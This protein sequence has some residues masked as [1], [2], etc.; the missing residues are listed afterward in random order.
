M[1]DLTLRLIITAITDGARD[2]LRQAQN[3]LND[4]RSTGEQAATRIRSVFT[5]LWAQMNGLGSRALSAIASGF[6]LIKSVGMSAWS[7]LSVGI[8]NNIDAAADFA[9]KLGGIRGGLLGLLAFKKSDFLDLWGGFAVRAGLLGVQVNEAKNF[10]SAFAD[11]KK[12]VEGTS[13]ELD[14]LEKTIKR[15]ASKEI[16]L[17]LVD[18][19]NITEAGGQLGVATSELEDFIKLASRSS[20]A[21]QG[22]T[23]QEAGSYIGGL[24]AVYEATI[25]EISPLIDQINVL[26]N[27]TNATE[28][29]ILN[30]LLMIGSGG[31]RFGLLRG[32][33]A[34][35]VTTMLSMKKPPDEVRTSLGSLFSA[36]TTG[37]MR[38][39]DFNASL[40]K[41]GLSAEQLALDIQANPMQALL[42]FLTVLGRFS[43][44]EQSNLLYGLFGQGTDVQSIGQLSFA[45][46]TLRANIDRVKEPAS[47][48][49]SALREFEKRA[50]TLENKL[51]LARNA[52]DILNIEM[53]NPFLAPVKAATDLFHKLMDSLGR[54]AADHPVL[55]AFIRIIALVQSL[56][57]VLN[58]LITVLPLATRALLQFL[59]VL[60]GTPFGGFAKNILAATVAVTVL[61]GVVGGFNSLLLSVAIAL[62]LVGY[63]AVKAFQAAGAS[64]TVF[65]AILT[66]V[67][68]TV[69]SL[70]LAF[71]GG[72]VKFVII[73]IT[74][75][76]VAY[77]NLQD[78]L[79][80]VGGI[81]AKVSNV[82][83]AA[84]RLLSRIVGEAI[85]AVGGYISQFGG[86]LLGLVGINETTWA[87]ITNAIKQF[88]DNSPGQIKAWAN[89][90][91]GALIW[92]KDN[93]GIRLDEFV[94]I[95]RVKFKG[96]VELAKAAG[97]DIK[98]AL[99]GK[100]DTSNIDA[101][102]AA[103]TTDTDK[104]NQN[105]DQQSA[106]AG[107]KDFGVDY[108]GNALN[109]ADQVLA[110][111]GHEIADEIKREG[112]KNAI[113]LPP[114]EQRGSSVGNGNLGLGDTGTE[115][116]KIP[117]DA[118]KA[119]LDL[120]L[121]AI[122][123]R[124][125]A[126]TAAHDLE[127]KQLDST[128]NAQKLELERQVVEQT[129]T[130]QQKNEQTLAL[131]KELDDKKLTV[132][133]Q[134]IEASSGLDKA[135]IL[136][137]K[138]AEQASVPGGAYAPLLDAAQQ[139]QRLPD[140]LLRAVMQVESQGNLKAVSPA[141]A[142]GLMQLMP[143][144]AKSLGVKDVF[145]PK[146]NIEGGAKLL[147]ELLDTFNGDVNKA[148]AA[149]NSNPTKVKA[150]QGDI[151][152]LPAETQAYV[153]KVQ[154]ELQ[155]PT[156]GGT[157]EER[158]A[159][160]NKIK[161]LDNEL[162]A[163][164]QDRVARLKNLG[165]DEQANATEQSTA[166]LE[167][168][169]TTLAEQKALTEA[170]L[171]AGHDAALDAVTVQEQA[172]QQ[173][174]DLG[175]LTASEHLGRLRQFAADRLAIELK[176]LNEK[177]KLL[178]DDKLALAQNLD[179]QK[180][181]IRKFGLDV[182]GINNQ[183]ATNNKAIFE[184]MMAPFKNAL[185][186]MT[187]G[188][189]T[190]QQTISNAVRNAANSMLV[191]Y[192]STFIQERVM[193]TAQ[194]AWKLSGI[195]ATGAAE[196]ALKNGD[197][198]YAMLIAA[199]EK[200]I[201]AAQ[202]AWEAA[203]E[204]RLALRKRAIKLASALW[205]KAQWVKDK[206]F[207][208]AQWAWELL[209]F[210]EKEAAKVATKT[211]TETV[212]TTAQVTNDVVRTGSTIA[213]NETAQASTASKAKSSI[214]AQAAEAAVSAYNA[215]AS[216]PYIGP[217]LGAVAAVAAFAAMMAYGAMIPSSKKGL[218]SVPE[219]RMQMVHEQETILPAGVADNFRSV[220]NF[221]KSNG[222]QATDVSAV[223]GDL[224]AN[225]QLHGNWA[226][227]KSIA[228]LPQQSSEQAATMAQAARR[229]H[230]TATAE[231]LAAMQPVNHTTHKTINEGDTHFNVSAVDGQSVKR[232][233]ENHGDTLA[234]VVRDKARTGKSLKS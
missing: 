149:Y 26:G 134:Y 20:V 229:N 49:G 50:D 184:G 85:D 215:M 48:A 92:L 44:L 87:R 122:K 151:K 15:M 75:L 5:V 53:G 179:D 178:K 62:G 203:G 137:K 17:K 84:W 12:V 52:L 164:E 120:Q 146:Q 177:R 152:K 117:T 161:L 173:E 190:G 234:R 216:I 11:V 90:V 186:Q 129:I 158:Q 109:F 99:A 181:L 96:A 98:D 60:A 22:L 42:N 154:A 19:A 106:A 74:S 69:G 222:L 35:L 108:I 110:D 101:Q 132:E 93:A 233:L 34:A 51:Q 171:Q 144:T 116:P 148:L 168:K 107:K 169:K 32:E 174:L 227:P 14:T 196:K 66:G 72:W 30:S 104:I 185:Q 29:D 25:K 100:F 226:I 40:A 36:L 33:M 136:S 180:A 80:T 130:E 202:W 165:I 191:T 212:M 94:D 195:K 172:A 198:I 175:T 213:A 176:L 54:F 155:N 21:F 123:T 139:K 88:V 82:I 57:I 1:N 199:K 112:E 218:W 83:A 187:N 77:T 230:D 183:L 217:V 111:L 63:N 224:V 71:G 23:P 142:S 28:R 162:V 70:L 193:Q 103:N 43:N 192:A 37:E 47:Y 125:D 76:I 160:A 153:P 170:Q 182:Q 211:I 210:G 188:V 86:W 167:I 225:G 200:A 147:R 131:R 64:A 102:L 38:G 65:G 223:V 141:G 113:T 105:A 27:T 67:R 138:Q 135:A 231:K 56:S 78:K 228:T 115:T 126:L 159:S 95:L 114:P 201:L 7:A 214:F 121:A 24:S 68:T 16:P 220:V 41:M 79:V 127:L 118:I 10:E 145:D 156:G 46:D 124:S 91:V 73:A 13:D 89:F 157:I 206:V 3:S 31:Q 194:W 204:Q 189:L 150:A 143:A 45:V 209:G 81:N 4:L 208:A 119:N 205:E 39:K 128:F 61:T 163:V 59:A 221:V 219:D 9:A 133:R 166:E 140:G 207:T 97:R 55:S 6:G 197:V 18:I 232:L 58:I 2:G 8:K